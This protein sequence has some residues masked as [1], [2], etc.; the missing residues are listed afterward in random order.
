MIKV[1]VYGSFVKNG[2]YHRHFIEGS[3][4]LGGGYVEGYS[5]YILGGV[6]GMIPRAGERV[7]GEVYELDQEQ[8]KKM[9][10]F[11]HVGTSFSRKDIDV[12]M[13]NGTILQAQAHIWNGSV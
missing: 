3:A 11:M 7:Q 9:D 1:F 8:L 10:S 13:E 12:V 2:R 5:K 4:F 6:D